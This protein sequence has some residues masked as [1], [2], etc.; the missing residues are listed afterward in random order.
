MI[1]P[2]T[3]T[4]PI[5][6]WWMM[7]LLTVVLPAVASGLLG[8]RLLRS[9][10][11]PLPTEQPTAPPGI[12]ETA[13]TTPTAAP[14][15]APTTV[16]AA[17]PMPAAYPI[18]T[19]C[20]QVPAPRWTTLYAEFAAELGCPV[21]AEIST[22][23]SEIPANGAFQYYERGTMVWRQ[24]A[25]IIYVLYDD[26]TY[27]AFPD[28]SPAGY[29]DSELLKGGF[30]YLWN[31]N[32]DVRGLIGKPLAIEFAAADF[33]LQDFASGTI[34]YFF[35]NGGRTYVLFAGSGTWLLRQE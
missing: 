20:P 1:K 35:D 22:A 18:T 25:D 7:I 13:A 23:G 17:T 2:K 29:F 3:M 28:D 16:P 14:T 33:A 30:G 9:E 19:A 12:M 15:I 8:C 24:H 21:T 32:A 34:F 26:G 4:A 31:T 6:P 10:E 11:Q 27:V 5:R